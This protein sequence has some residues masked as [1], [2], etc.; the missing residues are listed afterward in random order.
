MSG[1]ELLENRDP[2]QPMSRLWASMESLVCFTA[3]P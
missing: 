1:S 2:E 3:I